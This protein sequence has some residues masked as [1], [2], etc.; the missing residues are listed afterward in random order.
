M[1]S[2]TN[3]EWGQT[4]SLPDRFML[5]PARGGAL[6]VVHAAQSV[7]YVWTEDDKWL[8]R[9]Q[10]TGALVDTGSGDTVAEA[11]SALFQ[12]RVEPLIV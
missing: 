4:P 1:I 2:Q 11:V 5:V 3:P 6:E 7:G 10:T 9:S 12:T 8:A